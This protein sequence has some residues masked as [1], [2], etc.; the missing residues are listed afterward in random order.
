MIWCAYNNTNK[1]VFL[2][3]RPSNTI[4]NMETVLI[5]DVEWLPYSTTIQMLQSI[6]VKTNGK[7][8]S[9]AEFNYELYRRNLKTSYDLG[10]KRRRPGE[11]IQ[12]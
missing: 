7:I 8:L 6:S 3:T 10:K 5:D 9:I 11:L 1:Y 4:D 2:P 12:S